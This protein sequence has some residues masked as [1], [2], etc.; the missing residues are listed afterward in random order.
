MQRER[1][2]L[3]RE[4]EKHKNYVE[5]SIRIEKSG[6]EEMK[7]VRERLFEQQAVGE[8]LKKTVTRLGNDNKDLRGKIRWQDNR[9]G[10][11]EAELKGTKE[12]IGKLEMEVE[13]RD[14]KIGD[15]EEDIVDLRERLRAQWGENIRKF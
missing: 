4:R 7:K 1:G 3:E 2:I 10:D 5:R 12:E 13:V 9:I 8:R 6:V 11:L 15:M 14:R